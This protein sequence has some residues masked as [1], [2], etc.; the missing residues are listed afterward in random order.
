[1]ATA[2]TAEEVTPSASHY[3]PIP[4][5]WSYA[6]T[7]LA[8]AFMAEDTTDVEDIVIDGAGGR[9][10]RTACSAILRES[11]GRKCTRRRLCRPQSCG[12]FWKRAALPKPLDEIHRGDEKAEF[13][14]GANSA[15]PAGRSA[16]SK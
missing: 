7:K 10:R 5:I 2:A 14:A 3:G 16:S 4:T 8:E 1:M 9:L 12:A 13:E 11:R 6:Q 15:G